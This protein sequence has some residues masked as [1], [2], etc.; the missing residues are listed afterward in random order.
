MEIKT[1]SSIAHEILSWADD[2]GGCAVVRKKQT[3][4]F[5]LASEKCLL[6]L[7]TLRNVYH[8]A[9][10]ILCKSAFFRVSC[11]CDVTAEQHPHPTKNR[12]DTGA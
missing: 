3:K 5:K 7:C 11:L 4:M 2:H 8:T 6:K 9:M 1:N 12:T 10:E